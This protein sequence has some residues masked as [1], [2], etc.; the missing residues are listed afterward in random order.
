MLSTLALLPLCL[1][2]DDYD[3]LRSAV[4]ALGDINEDGVP[5]LALAHRPRPFGMG[6][7]PTKGWPRVE[8]EP[9]VW[10]ISGVDGSVLHALRGPAAFGTELAVVGDLDGDGAAELAVGGGR[11][12]RGMG[13]G[14]VVTIVS[15]GSGTELARLEAP[16]K[17]RAFGRALAGGVQLTGDPTPDLVI[18]AHGGAFVIDGVLL[19]PTWI[20]E[21]RAG[22]LVERRAAEGVTFPFVPVS[23]RPVWPDELS[24]AW[25]G[26][27]YPGMNVSAVCD[28]D[29]D[30][31]GEI[32]LS[33]PR[34]P[35][36]GEEEDGLGE[37]E[38]KDSRTR[39]VFSGGVRKPLSLE[40]A[41]WCVVS[42]EDLDG[43]EVPDLITTTVNVHTRAWS[44][45]SGELLWEVDYT[46]GYKHAE[47]T[48]LAVTSDHDGDGVR[49]VA[50]GEN[51]T[52]WDADRG[53][54]A[55]LSGRTGEELKRHRTLVTTQPGPPN[56]MVGGADVAVLGDLDGDGLEE[57]AVWE[58]VPQRLLLLK[59]ADL[60]TL[61]QVD[62]TSLARPE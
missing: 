9:V 4:I 34:E 47:G 16:G 6:A 22:C 50:V 32:A 28:L 49:D 58:P 45:T 19:E 54:V 1:A 42:G 10:L 5:D 13:G 53:G 29:G 31:L 7:A 15:T 8:Q 56:E 14:G 37:A 46:G 20:L 43:D 44:G 52:F 18:G 48:S 59:G 35:A 23:E 51:E 24:P 17:A 25:G 61:W 60:H 62:V 38:Q 11:L 41:G 21:P 57:L 2:F 39:I 36:C 55:I 40:T 26:G 30:G 27:T 12:G 3:G 33:T